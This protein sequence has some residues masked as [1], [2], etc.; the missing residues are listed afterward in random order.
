MEGAANLRISGGDKALSEFV[1]CVMSHAL[2][3]HSVNQA[4]QLEFP[5]AAPDLPDLCQQPKY[6]MGDTV[7]SRL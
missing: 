3:L 2:Q 1:V 5:T 7:Q 6:S 4:P